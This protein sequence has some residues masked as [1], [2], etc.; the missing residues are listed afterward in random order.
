MNQ[1]ASTDPLSLEREELRS[2]CADLLAVKATI[3]N[4]RHALT[5]EL[6]VGKKR[7]P[8]DF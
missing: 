7:T 6:S 3:A 2:I 4:R 5:E 1:I 8:F